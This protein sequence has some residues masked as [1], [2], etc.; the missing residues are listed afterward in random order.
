L[1]SR[2]STSSTAVCPVVAGDEHACSEA[3][4]ILSDHGRAP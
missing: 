3:R 1:A 4:P 2:S